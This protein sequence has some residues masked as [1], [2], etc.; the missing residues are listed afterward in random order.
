MDKSLIKPEFPDGYEKWFRE[1]LGKKSGL[2]FDRLERHYETVSKEALESFK[3]WEVWR[4]II[5]GLHD[6]DDK[7][8]I[9]HG[10]P[11]ITEY[12]PEIIRKPYKSFFE[13]TYRR[14]VLNNHS[15]PAPPKEG[16]LVPPDWYTE[17][18]DIIRTTLVVK[19]LD[20]VEFII[21]EIEN[22]AVDSGIYMEHTL[23]SKEE[24]YYAGH[25]ILMKSVEV[26][27]T[28]FDTEKRDI[29][30]EIQI[31][32]QVKEVIKRLLHK[33]YEKRRIDKGE[34]KTNWRWDY[35]SDE[36]VANYLGHVLH[37]VE[38]M[39]LEVRDRSKG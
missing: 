6:F 37:Y 26:T 33:F 14:N 25:V 23:E 30:F 15:Y 24:G 9:E 32:T 8:K 39:I 13:K 12:K 19:Y 20:G 31:T 2:P 18:N 17:V 22:I 5:D 3:S 4:K 38:G 11:L 27:K 1:K 16:W 21:K 29:F 35:K 7:Y 34:E 10:Y 28:D 36:F